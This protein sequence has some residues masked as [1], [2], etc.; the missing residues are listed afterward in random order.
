MAQIP[1]QEIKCY[2]CGNKTFTVKRVNSLV[3]P[4]KAFISITCTA[5]GEGNLHPLA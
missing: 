4:N 2:A 1:N 5:C 3:N